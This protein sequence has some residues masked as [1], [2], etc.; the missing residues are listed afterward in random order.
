[1][2]N[3]MREQSRQARHKQIL[4]GLLI[5]L[6][7]AVVYGPAIGGDFIWDDH[8]FLLENPLI[9]ADNGL[10]RFWFSTEATDY[11]PLTS[12]LLWFEW[13]LFGPDPTGYHIVNLL[14]HG[15][16]A[17]LLWL[18]LRRLRVPGAWPAALFFA[19]HPVNAAS[20]AWIS[21]HK[22]TLSAALYLG[23]LLAFV[24]HREPRRLPAALRWD[25]CALGL[26]GLALL[27]KTSVVVLP[28]VLLL[29]VLWHEQ[30]IPRQAWLD[31]I[32]FFALAA[33][34]GLVTVWFQAHNAIAGETVRTDGLL[35]RLAT[36][37]RA[38]WFYLAK[39]VLPAR[40]SFIYP[41]WDLPAAGPA[42]FLPLA[43]LAA[44][45]A[46]LWTLR[47]TPARGLLFAL[48]YFVLALMPVLGLLNMYWMQF[49]LVADHWQYLAIMGIAALA[50]AACER[51]T[52]LPGRARYAGPTLAA[53]LALTLGVLTHQRARILATEAALWPDTVARNPDGWL[54]RNNWGVLLIK[55]K[56]F[57]Q[58][59]AQCSQA[60][61]IKPD[62][63]VAHYNAG[64]AYLESGRPEQAMRHYSESLRLKPGNPAALNNMGYAAARAHRED[65]AAHWYSRALEVDPFYNS[66]HVN[67]GDLLWREHQLEQAVFHYSQA[68]LTDPND[69]ELHL[70]LAVILFELA[71][72]EAATTPP[73]DAPDP[74]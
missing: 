32:P 68:L 67:L 1:M 37:G 60:L 25:W 19:L 42:D 15:L 59:I 6:A 16:S 10:R 61:R 9:H 74:H 5:L 36:A 69:A 55:Q 62:Y 20:A 45:A 66:A 54:P 23:A 4:A 34:L 71:K 11:F 22:N 40:L 73:T 3:R 64:N 12:S 63:W 41:R 29:C 13:R 57:E 28:G 8:V 65:L 49:S 53:L 70:K 72:L 14:L 31:T 24:R 18:L 2:A 26:F 33:A 58:A 44:T 47:R 30:K 38:V 21:E 7:T 43:A 56:K 27:S 50:G 35:S 52:R 17:I 51:L 39:A 48:A 46:L